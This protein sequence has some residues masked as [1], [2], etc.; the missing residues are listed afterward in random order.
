M[1]PLEHHADQLGALGHPA[2]L[3]ILRFIV[4][5][6]AKGVSTTDVQAEIDIP[7]TTLHHHLTR[8]VAAGLVRAERDGKFAMHTADFAALKALTAFV[9]EDCC[10]RGRGGCC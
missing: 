10:Q 7:W 2:R 8:L 6:G 9:W 4:R 1:D 3:A 5:A